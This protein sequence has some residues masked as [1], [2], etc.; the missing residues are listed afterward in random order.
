MAS[1]SSI[2][3]TLIY[4][5]IFDFPLTK[6]EIWKFL[7]AVNV[8]RA[9]FEKT[10]TEFPL[11]KW[12]HEKG[13]YFLSGRGEIVEKRIKK[14]KESKKKITLAKKIIKKL[15]FFPTVLFIGI[16]GGLA[17]ENSKEKDDIDLFVITRANTLWITRLLLVLLLILMG[18]Y[19]GR[20][21]KESQKICL[22]MLIDEDAL[23]FEKDR[24]NLYAAHEIAQL[25]PIFNRNNTYKKFLNVN[26]RWVSR[27][28]PNAIGRIT[29]YESR[30]KERKNPL[31]IFE[32]VAKLVQLI[33]MKR[34]RTREV[35]SDHF[36]AFHPFEY[37]NYVLEEYNRRLKKYEI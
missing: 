31:F 5:D 22:N 20:G 21:K 12:E 23:M 29:N 36:L 34:H 14:K 9:S 2:L 17:L 28:L 33:Y 24:Q 4:S 27:F 15:S 19:R 18:Q 7:I 32:K 13:F 16:S 37:K 10:L 6:E 25:K 1:N 30:I 11:V 3:K 35:I 26:R 8:D